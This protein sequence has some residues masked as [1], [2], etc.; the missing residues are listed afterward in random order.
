M[1]LL[2][3]FVAHKEAGRIIGELVAGYGELEFMLALLVAQVINDQDTAFKV[4]FRAR[5]ESNRINVADALARPKV[6]A[7]KDRYERTIGCLRHA[8]KIRNQYAHSQ[9]GYD[10]RGLWFVALEEVAMGNAPYDL[11]GLS[12]HEI[13]L[14]LLKDQEAFFVN[15]KA[16]IDWL[17]FER[18]FGA[19]R[20]STQPF[21]APPETPKPPLRTP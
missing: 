8:L 19:G 16:N 2:P 14:S 1:A 18:Q 7:N 12:Q 3:A 5:G 21:A 4:M 11:G 6:V 17:N 20:L 13:P 9:F 10:G 15:V